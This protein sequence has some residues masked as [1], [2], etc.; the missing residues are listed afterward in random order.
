MENGRNLILLTILSVLQR[1]VNR[2]SKEEGD[3]RNTI[4]VLEEKGEKLVKINKK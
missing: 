3:D 2:S 4:A 1:K